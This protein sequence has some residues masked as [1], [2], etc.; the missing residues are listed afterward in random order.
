MLRRDPCSTMAVPRSMDGA[1][2]A[3]G[4]VRAGESQ[5]AGGRGAQGPLAG[6]SE[7]FAAQTPQMLLEPSAGPIPSLLS[8]AAG[9]LIKAPAPAA[10]SIFGRSVAPKLSSSQ[11]GAGRW[12]VKSWLHSAVSRGPDLPP[13]APLPLGKTLTPH[14]EA[15]PAS[16]PRRRCRIRARGAGTGPDT[17]GHWWGSTLPCR[18]GIPTRIPLAWLVAG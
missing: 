2:G 5:A 6:S 9:L 16:L 11:D 4:G 10:V 3:S 14:G 1:Q 13:W 7:T 15:L 12:C 18:A 17:A 8:T